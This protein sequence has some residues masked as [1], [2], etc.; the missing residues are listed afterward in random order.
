MSTPA[1]ASRRDWPF[2][3]RPLSPALGAELVGIDFTRD[4]D[5]RLFASIYEAFLDYQLLLFRGQEVTP[6]RQVQFARHFG[7]VQ[8]HVLNQYHADGHPELYRLSNLDAEGRPKGQHP[9]RGTMAWHTDGSWRE[10][11]GQATILYAEV[12]PARGG[13]T[14]WC[15]TYGAYEGLDD[16]LKARL[17]GM[18]AIH[19][20]DFSRNRRHGEDPMTAAQRATVPPVEHPVVTVHPD[21]GRRAILLGDHAETIVG[22]PYDEGRALVEQL[23]AMIVRPELVYEHRWQPMDLMVWDNRCTLHK[24]GSYDVAGDRRVI[25]RCTVLGGRPRGIAR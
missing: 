17:D 12:V 18:H 10:V 2:E 4:I 20:L 24:A 23:N 21:T 11:T 5:E 16:A 1:T 25:R 7:E 15:D 3:A 9:D 6:A 8:V 22:M 19:N 13:G 14:A